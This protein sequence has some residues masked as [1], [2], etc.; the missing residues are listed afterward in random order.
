MNIKKFSIIFPTRERPGLLDRLLK[1]IVATTKN[2]NDIEVLVAYD[3]DDIVTKS[4]ISQYREMPVTWVECKRS[5]NLSRDYYSH[6]SKIADGRWIV[7]IN[8]DVEFKTKNWD[9]IADRIL[10]KAVGLGPD[11]I[12]GSVEDDLGKNRKTEF[13]DYTCFPILGKEG[14]DA[15]GFVFPERIPMWGADIWCRYIYGMVKRTVSIPIRISHI[16]HHNGTREQD[17][18]NLR[19]QVE[20]KLAQADVHPTAAEVNKLRGAIR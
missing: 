8:D 5:K 7:I 20:S 12:Y 9:V 14:V 4:Y 18:V 1:S 19:V 10:S 17:H 11:I 15:L 13:N 3:T 2:I 6:L 16:C